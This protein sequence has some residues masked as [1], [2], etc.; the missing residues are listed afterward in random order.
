M[1]QKPAR[2]LGLVEYNIA[3]C[4]SGGEG[5][6]SQPFEF[7]AAVKRAGKGSGEEDKDKT[8]K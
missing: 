4:R 3:T 2:L 8:S 7:K 6:N 1:I 5:G